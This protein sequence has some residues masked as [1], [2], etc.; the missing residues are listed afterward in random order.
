MTERANALVESWESRWLPLRDAR[1]QALDQL[2][3]T[4]SEQAMRTLATCLTALD[5]LHAEAHWMDA[6]FDSLLT[7]VLGGDLVKT[8]TWYDNGW[9]YANRVVDLMER[10]AATL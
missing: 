9:G 4:G 6:V 8:V 3:R 7:K 1:A 10:L 5:R 2:A